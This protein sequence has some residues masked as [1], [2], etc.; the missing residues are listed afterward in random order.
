MRVR[1]SA[2]NGG[3]T[4]SFN[5]PLDGALD[6]LSLGRTGHNCE[7]PR[8]GH[9]SWDGQRQSVA[10]HVVNRCERTIVYLLRAAHFVELDNLDRRRIFEIAERRID[11]SQVTVLSNAEYG[12]VRRVR[13]EQLRVTI[14]L[15]RPIIRFA[16]QAVEF[17]HSDLTDKTIDQKTP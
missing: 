14:A 8:S 3:R 6:R 15:R 11:K 1:M 13:H 7:Q 5:G 16:A 9:D 10:R 17:L 4:R 12:E 2:Q